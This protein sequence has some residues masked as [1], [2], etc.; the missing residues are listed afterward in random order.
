MAAVAPSETEIRSGNG[1][2]DLKKK[3][4]RENYTE[5]G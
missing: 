4:K 3:K 1:S 2:K 5:C